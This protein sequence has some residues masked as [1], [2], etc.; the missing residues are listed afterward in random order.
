MIKVILYQQDLYRKRMVYSL[1]LVYF[2]LYSNTNLSDNMHQNIQI[3]SYS[4]IQD[5][6]SNDKYIYNTWSIH[7]FSFWQKL[8]DLLPINKSAPFLNSTALFNKPKNTKTW[9]LNEY[10]TLGVPLEHLDNF[11]FSNYYS[12]WN[13]DNYFD[14]VPIVL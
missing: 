13:Y 5:M 8:D 14:T 2:Y 12:G 11:T 9:L 4:I 7:D 6:S 3:F 1:T 10:S